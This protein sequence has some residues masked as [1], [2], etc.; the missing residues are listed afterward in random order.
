M[1][2]YIPFI[3]VLDSWD[4]LL[5]SPLGSPLQAHDH[6]RLL[7][8]LE[9]PG[10]TGSEAGLFA[11]LAGDVCLGSRQL[12]GREYSAQCCCIQHSLSCLLKPSLLRSTSVKLKFGAG[13][14]MG[15]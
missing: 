15:R 7:D 5:G 11:N 12:R 2:P 10:A 14:R 6:L 8:K 13:G 9:V 4:S 3:L 1:G